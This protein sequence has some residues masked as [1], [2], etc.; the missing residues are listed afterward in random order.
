MRSISFAL[1]K[2]Q[3]L[4]GTKDVTRRL[5]W[6]TLKPGDR[7][8]AVEKAMGLRKGEHPVVL[9]VI[10]VVSVRRE[11]LF[12][13]HDEDVPREGF[14]SMTGDEFVAMFVKHMKCC[15]E[16]T[17]T[18]IEFRKVTDDKGAHHA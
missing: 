3:F 16:T 14:P 10:E 8:R 6:A 15:P 13:I 9:G 7:L 5:G 12:A 18:R 11:P 17:V 1:T 2:A 4:D